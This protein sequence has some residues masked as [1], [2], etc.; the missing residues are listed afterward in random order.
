[1]IKTFI[2]AIFTASTASL[3]SLNE[4]PYAPESLIYQTPNAIESSVAEFDK[5][6]QSALTD[7]VTLSAEGNY[8]EAYQNWSD[9]QFSYVS[10]DLL[11][12]KTA[13]LSS[14]NEVK[15]STP[16]QQSILK[17]RF[18]TLLASHPGLLDALISNAHAAAK[19]TPQQHFLT[20]NILKNYQ[21]PSSEKTAKISSA[22]QTLSDTEKQSFAYAPGTALP[23]DA[24]KLSQLN[25][26]T[27]NI[28]CFPGI[29]PYM[30]GGTSPWK[31]RIS[32]IVDTIL[33][34]KAEI[35][36]LQ[37]VWD[38]EAMRA[39]IKLLQNDYAHF[40][41]NAGDPSGTIDPE[42]MGYNSGLF[43]ASKL[44]L[45]S[46]SFERFVRSIPKKSNRGA[47]FA[48]CEAGKQRVA[49]INTHLQHGNLPEFREV[50]KEQLYCCHR[51]LMQARPNSDW[52]FLAGDL[53]INALDSN[54]Q[55]SGISELFEIPYA[56]DRFE[57]KMEKATCTDY[58]NDLVMTPFDRRKQVVPTFELLDYCIAPKGFSM[59]AK[60]V[61]KLIK[62]FSVDAPAKALSDHN[63]LLTTWTLSP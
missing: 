54:F 46:V 36:F 35:V 53:N 45:Q 51:L 30:Y 42:K 12:D 6:A 16:A 60:P 59:P 24:K 62:L 9:L 13:D 1:M 10:F 31:D 15:T 20:E 44:P 49:F 56:I 19:L 33:S 32:Q 40:F 18:K 5:L 28:L 17:N 58:F 34:A 50:R 38:P 22:L 4:L 61:Q 3:L 48:I 7:F 39:L 14:I 8:A 37:E 63:A 41:Y 57:K 55:E 29:L 47:F 11:L 52:G 21:R 25:V 23:V 27:A 2:A 43:I 26:L